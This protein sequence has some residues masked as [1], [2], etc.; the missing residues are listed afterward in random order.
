M[1]HGASDAGSLRRRPLGDPSEGFSCERRMSSACTH[2]RACALVTRI[3]LRD[4]AGVAAG[5]E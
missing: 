3:A 2:M 4:R 1:S 5:C